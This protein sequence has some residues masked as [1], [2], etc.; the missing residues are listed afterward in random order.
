MF[1]GSGFWEDAK[2]ACGVG[3]DSVIALGYISTRKLSVMLHFLAGTLMSKNIRP[4]AAVVNGHLGWG[5][6]F[7]E[8]SMIQ[9]FGRFDQGTPEIKLTSRQKVLV[10]WTPISLADGERLEWNSIDFRGPFPRGYRS[11]IDPDGVGL[12]DI[13]NSESRRFSGLTCQ[14]KGNSM[15]SNFVRAGKKIVAIGRNYALHVKELGN[16]MP[17]EPFFFLKPTSSYLP[18]GGKLEI[19]KGIVAHHEVELGLVIGKMG[20]DIPASQAE[21]YIAGYTEAPLALAVDMTARN[22]QQKVRKAGLPWS[23]AKGFDTFTPIG[24][25]IPKKD[26]V[27]AHNLQLNLAIN[28]KI[29]QDG[30]TADMI[31]RIPQL[32]EHVSSVMTLEEG[33]LLLTGTPD[34]VGPV[35]PGD[36]VSCALKDASGKELLKLEFD[37]VE[38]E[39]GYHF[40]E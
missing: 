8:Q 37:A 18:S 30:N 5:H 15:A 11:G 28:G 23:A 10:S 19:P 1:L 2:K 31:F 7:T 25:W 27:D 6:L 33:D 13:L 4:K 14:V 3:A 24:G 26:I 12:V 22:L 39:K 35:V 16:E 20:R 38:R 29:K 9:V 40:V 17:K 32:I 36:S 21:S 34:G